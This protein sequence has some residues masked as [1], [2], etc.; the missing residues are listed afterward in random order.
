MAAKRT[1]KTSISTKEKKQIKKTIDKNE[2]IQLNCDISLET[3][4]QIKTLQIIYPSQRKTIED[5]INN[6]FHEKKNEI[7]ELVLKKIGL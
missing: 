5:A 2:R 3:K 4:E 7:K 6:L 1:S